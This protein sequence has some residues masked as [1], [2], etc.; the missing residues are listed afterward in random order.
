[1]QEL[2]N[3]PGPNGYTHVVSSF[4]VNELD[5]KDEGGV[6]R[7]DAA[8]ALGAVAH[9]GRDRQ[10]GLGSLVELGDAFVPAFNDLADADLALEGFVALD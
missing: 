6:G 9:L 1:M 7:N 8:C 5:I 2:L 4:E 3:N 10:S